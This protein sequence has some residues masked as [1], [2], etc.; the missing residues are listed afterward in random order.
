MSSSPGTDRY[1]VLEDTRTIPRKV[2]VFLGPKHLPSPM[3]VSIETL[4]P[5]RTPGNGR[6]KRVR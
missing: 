2:R 1:E 4:I 3:M 6:A 5:E